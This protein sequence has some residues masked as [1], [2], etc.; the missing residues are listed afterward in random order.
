MIA[1][2]IEWV[3]VEERMPESDTDL[4]CI[5]NAEDAPTSLMTAYWDAARAT[6]ADGLGGLHCL[7][8]H[9]AEIKGP[10]AAEPDPS[11][12]RLTSTLGMLAVYMA[13]AEKLPAGEERDERIRMYRGRMAALCEVLEGLLDAKH[14]EMA[15]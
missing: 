6:W 5:V 11:V 9:W 13:R 1:E 15:E 8:T 2:V 3:P 14:E 10:S 7:A 4:V 12:I